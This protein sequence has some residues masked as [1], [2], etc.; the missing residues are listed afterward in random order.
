MDPELLLEALDRRREKLGEMQGRE[1]LSYVEVASQ[2]GVHSAMFSRLRKGNL[3]SDSNLES[4]LFW[5]GADRDEFEAC[6]KC[7][8]DHSGAD[9]PSD[10]PEANAHT[11]E[12]EDA[13]QGGTLAD[14]EPVAD[15][16]T[17]SAV[18]EEDDQRTAAIHGSGALSNSKDPETKAAVKRVRELLADGAVGVSIMHDMDPNTMPSPADYEEA[19]RKAYEDDDWADLE[20]MQAKIKSRPRHVAIVDTPAFSDAKLVLN[21]DGTVE[22]PIAFE[23]RWTGD[24]RRL[25][26]ESLQ[27]DDELLPIPI[28]WDRTDGDHSGMTVGL[29][30]TIWRV[31]GESSPVRGEDVSEEK[32]EAV[33]ASAGTKG[34]P[35]AYF[36]R[37][38]AKTATPVHIDAPDANGLRRVW[39]HAAPRGVC[40]RSDMG[41]C[42][43]YP[44]DVDKTHKGFHTGAEVA[45]DDGQKIRV[46]A[47]TMGGAH[48]D[49]G[50]SRKGVTASD[51]GTHRDNA[52]RTLAM[53]RAWEDNHGLA[54]SG[55]LMPDA[56]DA[57]L[58]RAQ[59][60]S[61]SVEL[62]P[63]RGGRTL[64]GI[65][66]VPTPAWPVT[67]SAGG[68]ELQ[69][70]TTDSVIVDDIGEG[71]LKEGT[72]EEVKFELD[73]EDLAP[74]TERL[75]RIEKALA[76]LVDTLIDDVP[77]PE[78]EPEEGAPS[79]G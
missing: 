30:D 53:V 24:T 18:V 45:L 60:N 66:L 8:T 35:A 32:V 9:A 70:P 33:V 64:V 36:Q 20:E 50:L 52:N 77:E 13:A 29:V 76:L 58:L 1:P 25:P 14:E 16:P 59:S 46:G 12:N 74:L 48:L 61:P 56:S 62:W 69:V 4:L 31:D 22:G 10:E 78:E 55:V 40:H 5:L 17:P 67:A 65:H 23:G 11:V 6:D 79:N 19:E 41:G 57:D 3:P 21:S 44:G 38:A 42:F 28:I 7:P 37:F 73:P 34:L 2:L 54:F 68:A 27:W 43:Q 47:L 75:D 71:E 51:T 72:I 39:G 63:E 49:V 26:Y 15:G